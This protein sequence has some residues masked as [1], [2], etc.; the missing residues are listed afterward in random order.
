MGEARRLRNARD[1]E[2]QAI[3]QMSKLLKPILKRF[4]GPDAYSIR[5]GEDGQN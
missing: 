1:Y 5:C 3:A 2:R 4:K